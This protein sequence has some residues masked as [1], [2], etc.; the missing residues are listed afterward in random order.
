MKHR[1]GLRAFRESDLEL[2]HAWT[3]DD[4]IRFNFRFA[5][6]E[7][8]LKD[9]ARFLNQQ[10]NRGSD[11]PYINFVLYDLNDVTQ[12][13]IGSV[14]LKAIDHEHRNAELTIVIASKQYRGR[15][16][17]QEALDLICSYGF[18]TLGLHRIY[19][20]CIAHNL[21]AIRAYEK[22][23]FVREGVSRDHIMQQGVYYD[24]ITMAI[25]DYEYRAR[26]Y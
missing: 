21:G 16:Y 11:D 6:K 1:I 18:N 15:G 23:G 17:G 5:S 9:S 10:L 14:G 24:E 8:T 25:L 4:R 3:S 7:W 19:L 26:Y 2:M 20:R 13:Y 22:F 12:K